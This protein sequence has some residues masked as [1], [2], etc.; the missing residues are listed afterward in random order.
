MWKHRPGGWKLPDWKKPKQQGQT[1]E[2]RTW[3][4]SLLT[5]LG[6]FVILVSLMS[7]IKRQRNCFFFF[8]SLSSNFVYSVIIN[9]THCMTAFWAQKHKEYVGRQR[10]KKQKRRKEEDVKGN[11]SEIATSKAEHGVCVS[12]ES[13]VCTGLCLGETVQTRSVN[14]NFTPNMHSQLELLLGLY[15]WEHNGFKYVTKAQVKMWESDPSLRVCGHYRGRQ[16]VTINNSVVMLWWEDTGKDS[17]RPGSSKQR[18][19]GESLVP[20][21]GRPAGFKRISGQK[22]GRLKLKMCLYSGGSPLIPKS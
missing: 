19:Q 3:R 20:V 12:L 13:R 9:Q 4:L 16:G 10:W 1:R 14:D 5:V 15:L 17:G 18:G 7:D 2:R 11:V 21:T 22:S 8:L 6:F